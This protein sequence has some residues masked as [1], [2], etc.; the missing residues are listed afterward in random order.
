MLYER[1][2]ILRVIAEMGR[3]LRALR[4]AATE[5]IRLGMLDAACR[6]QCGLSLKAART[7]DEESLRALLPGE[8]LLRLSLLLSACAETAP[9]DQEE[10]ATLRARSLRLM[11]ASA[12]GPE[13]AGALAETL[14]QLLR[15]SLPL[16]TAEELLA[17]AAFFREGGRY[18]LMDNAAFFL[19]ETLAPAGR[20]KHRAAL[21][22]LYDSLEETQLS[23]CGMSR[24]D[25]ADSL[26][27]LHDERMVKP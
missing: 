23:G 15:T 7:L 26:R 19:W 3:M 24:G 6:A 20:D 13:A 25:I 4:D 21:T 10:A 2:Y 16:L 14:D 1:D 12:R 22:A 27:L 17:C 11:L 5:E 18:D 8:T 9:M